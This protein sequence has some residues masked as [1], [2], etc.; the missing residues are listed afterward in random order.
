M[1]ANE[2]LHAWVVSPTRLKPAGTSA[3]ISAAMLADG[4]RA[5]SGMNFN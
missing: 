2:L 5:G 1:P 3:S 4:L